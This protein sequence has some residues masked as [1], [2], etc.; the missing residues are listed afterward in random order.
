M[1]TEQRHDL[2]AILI[3]GRM[4]RALS[5]SITFAAVAFLARVAN[6]APVAFWLAFALLTI[7]GVG[8]G[9]ELVSVWRRRQAFAMIPLRVDGAHRPSPTQ[10]TASV[11][12][13]ARR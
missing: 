6:P 13:A 3:H 7:G 5:A 2:A 9:H 8:L 4:A 10:V 11:G 12:S 1:R